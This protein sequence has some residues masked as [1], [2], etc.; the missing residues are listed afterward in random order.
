MRSSYT[1]TDTNRANNNGQKLEE[2]IAIMLTD[3]NIKYETQKKIGISLYGKPMKVDFYLPEYNTVIEAKNQS[4]S[5]SVDEKYVYVYGNFLK[6]NQKGM[7]VYKGSGMR[8]H[9]LEYLKSKQGNNFDVFEISELSDKLRS[10]LEKPI[11][12]RWESIV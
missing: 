5:G 3:M 9:A 8:S 11:A 1:V 2:L 7:V 4:S 6:N 10:F 12:E